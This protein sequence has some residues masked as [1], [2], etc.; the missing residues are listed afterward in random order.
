MA[1]LFPAV[2]AGNEEK[3]DTALNLDIAV[4][5]SDFFLLTFRYPASWLPP[6]NENYLCALISSVLQIG[7]LSVH[8]C[9]NRLET[10]LSHIS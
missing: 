2:G 6:N 4:F 8:N 1:I 5:V 9:R 3:Q 7:R 10:G